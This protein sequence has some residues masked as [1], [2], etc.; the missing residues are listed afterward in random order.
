MVHVNDTMY[1]A[2]V[3]LNN[4]GV[5]LMQ[6]QRFVDGLMTLKD[7]L[8]LMKNAIHIYP[9]SSS[10]PQHEDVN[11]ALQAA[12][13]RTSRIQRSDTSGTT[14]YK[15]SSAAHIVVITDQ[16]SPF[17]VYNILENDP[18]TICCVRIDPVEC[19]N[20][21]SDRYEVESSIIMYNYAIAHLMAS[22]I[23]PSS[24]KD[25][26]VDR[27]QLS[28]DLFELAQSV[29][30]AHTASLDE[31]AIPSNVLLISMLVATYL[32]QLSV[33]LPQHHNYERRSCKNLLSLELVL[34]T[35]ANHEM[36]YNATTQ[37]AAACA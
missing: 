28:Y 27:F 30:D 29:I 17:D 1:K 36:L 7:A 5:T 12:W 37:C 13:H 26:F 33:Q 14:S 34:S 22:S 31:F 15:L 3:A 16:D 18:S 20:C 11:V 8:R 9:S 25:G 35:I 2:V 23:E 10:V 19:T 4:A 6:H 32:Y 24:N 21:D